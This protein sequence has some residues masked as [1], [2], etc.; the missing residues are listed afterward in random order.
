MKTQRRISITPGTAIAVVAL[1]LALGGS[2]FAVGER[3]QAAAANQQRCANGAVRGFAV[4]TGDPRQGIANVPGQFTANAAVFRSRFNCN[5]RG[6]QVR[7]VG[8]GVYEVRFV[9]NPSGA[10][11]VTGHGAPQASLEILG[12]G[13][14]RVS[15][16]ALGIRDGV[17]LPFTIVAF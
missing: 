10:A 8:L 5:G 16:H 11:T 7:R 12:G 2:A 1:F 4:V 9:G 17:D 6:V 15:L 14:F 3:V 13:L